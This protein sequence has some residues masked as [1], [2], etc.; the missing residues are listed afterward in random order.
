MRRNASMSRFATVA[1]GAALAVAA[2]GGATAQQDYPTRPIQLMVAFPAGGS[3]DIAARIVASIAEKE[4]G[5]SIVVVNKGG[6]GGQGGWTDFVRPRPDGYYI[7]F[8][9]LP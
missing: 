8:I 9:N 4:I 6:A 5:Q 2:V 3:T 7:G 1:F